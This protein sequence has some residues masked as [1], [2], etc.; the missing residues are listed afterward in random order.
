M[1]YVELKLVG[2]LTQEQ[3]A[4]IVEEFSQTLE[5]VANKPR[6]ATYIVI[7]EMPAANWGANGKLLG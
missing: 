4:K 6:S 5:R 7:E 2:K 1:P 3:K